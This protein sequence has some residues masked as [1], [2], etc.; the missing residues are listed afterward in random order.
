MDKL[1]VTPEIEARINKIRESSQKQKNYTRAVQFVDSMIDKFPYGHPFEN[2][3][4]EIIDLINKLG[5]IKIRFP[6]TDLFDDVSKE[7]DIFLWRFNSNS[8][9]YTFS[10]DF[11]V[12][13][14]QLFIEPFKFE[15]YLLNK[16]DI[17]TEPSFLRTEGI[18]LFFN[19]L[20]DYSKDSKDPED[21]EMDRHYNVDN[22][23]PLKFEVY[24]N[25]RL[26]FV[27]FLENCKSF[28]D[29]ESNLLLSTDLIEQALESI[30]SSTL[31]RLKVWYEHDDTKISLD[32]VIDL[33]IT[34][35]EKYIIKV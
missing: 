17:S 24:C 33:I 26:V 25:Y 29:D 35:L 16:I 23:F 7:T 14:D 31:N 27:E 6:I 18:I 28:I 32:V 2:N 11:N 1:I 12:G 8:S 30:R 19:K 20:L 13:K 15:D 10:Y 34:W 4:Y 5:L 22:Y 3:F 21:L 9:P